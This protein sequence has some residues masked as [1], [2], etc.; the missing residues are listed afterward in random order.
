MFFKKKTKFPNYVCMIDDA[1]DIAVFTKD[2]KKIYPENKFVT[3]EESFNYPDK[4]YFFPI[5]KKMSRELLLFL[6]HN[7]PKGMVVYD[8]YGHMIGFEFYEELDDKD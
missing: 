6:K 4:Y 2:C 7:A 3:I 5:K 8:D 1:N